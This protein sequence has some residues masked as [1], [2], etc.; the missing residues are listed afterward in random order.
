MNPIRL[1]PYFDP[2]FIRI[3]DFLSKNAVGDDGRPTRSPW[4]WWI[5]R[6]NF[7]PLVSCA[8]HGTSHEEWASRIGIW[9]SGGEIIGLV[10][11]EG[12]G[13]GEAF[14]QSGRDELPSATL[15][16]MFEFIEHRFR[17]SDAVNLRIDPRFARRER[18]AAER[19]YAKLD[20][21]EPSSWLEAGKSPSPD[22]PIGYRL[23][24]GGEV[25]VQD[26]AFL[27][28]RAFGYA[29]KA[30]SLPGSIRAF[31]RLVLAPDYRGELDLLALDGEGQPASMVGLW[32]DGANGWG[33][34]EPVGTA[35]EHCKRGLAKAL[36]GEGA[37]RLSAIAR[38]QGGSFEG[39]WVGS[40][41][42]FYLSLG[43]EVKNRWGVWRK[44]LAG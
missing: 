43:F 22:M 12:E 41:Q 3:R 28:A 11:T 15:E 30:D 32:Y 6:W 34:L 19:G 40:D 29:D 25:P 39:I 35:P 1:K 9:E 33:I 7:T 10:L 38:R 8:M 31:E 36:V 14:I 42:P 17:E 37:R 23:A 27:H 18:M 26:K 44:P 16:E 5:D 20:W 13:Y 21:A 4:N 24:V 2:D